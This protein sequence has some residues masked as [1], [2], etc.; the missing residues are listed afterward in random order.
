[1]SVEIAAP[2]E[3]VWALV[4]EADHLGTWFGDAGATIDLH[5]GG[6]MS[7]TW[8]EHGTALVRVEQVQP[9]TMLAFVW[10]RGAGREPE[11][12]VMTRVVFRLSSTAAGTRVWVE[13]TGFAALTG[14]DEQR[15]AARQDNIGGWNAEIG[16]LKQYAEQR[17]GAV[18]E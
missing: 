10:G 6:A 15:E 3:R 5:P 8:R 2:I 18:R 4:S 17:A 12:G 9:P 14:T 13:E 1:M 7:L 11:P 16:E